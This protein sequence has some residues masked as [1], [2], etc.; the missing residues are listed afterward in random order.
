LGLGGKD[1]AVFE[2]APGQQLEIVRNHI[3]APRRGGEGAGR[4][5]QGQGA[6]GTDPEDEVALGAGRLDDIDD[7]ALEAGGDVDVRHRLLQLHDVGGGQ[8]RGQVV[9]RLA[10][11]VGLQDVDARRPVRIAH[12]DPHQEPVELGFGQW[13]GALVLDRVLGGHHHERPLEV[14]GHGVDGDLALLHGLEERRLRLG[15]CPVDLVGQDDVGEDAAGAELELVAGP[16]PHR[17]PGHV[18]REEVGRE[19][20]AVPRAVDRAGDGLGQHRLAHPGDVLDEQVPIGHEAGQRHLDDVAL[21]L[22]DPLD[23]AHEGVELLLERRRAKRRL[24]C[25]WLLPQ[26]VDKNGHP[27]R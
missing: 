5:L 16:V 24:A 21:A 20:D 10:A 14:V 4:P 18:G 19:L 27:A 23:V 17:D 9:D 8:H 25:H 22:D 3:V 15:G 12:L 7:V 26:G 13:V 11:A 2:H 1:Q 6:P